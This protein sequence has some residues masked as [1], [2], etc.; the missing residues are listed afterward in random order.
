MYALHVPASMTCSRCIPFRAQRLVG[1]HQ[2]RGPQRCPGPVR[3]ALPDQGEDISEALKADLER[4][5]A[6]SGAAGPSVP[7]S[8]SNGFNNA[9]GPSQQAPQQPSDPLSGV[10]DA[11]DKVSPRRV[12]PIAK[13]LRHGW[14]WGMTGKW[15]D[16]T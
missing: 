15:G 9:S 16:R 6:K 7:G 1:L 10:K 5:R 12:H 8:S 13:L 14:G 4:L 3:K 11:V 2:V